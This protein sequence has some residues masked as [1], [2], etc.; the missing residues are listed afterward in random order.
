VDKP[1][2]IYSV[3]GLRVNGS[4][5][6]ALYRRWTDRGQKR[7]SSRN[8]AFCTLD[9]VDMQA[10]FHNG[11]RFRAV[12]LSRL[13]CFAGKV[14]GLCLAV[15]IYR[16]PGSLRTSLHQVLSCRPMRSLQSCCFACGRFRFVHA[17]YAFLF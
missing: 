6:K 12:L 15:S 8:A 11:C 9:P 10:F 13:A 2:F 17:A 7:S 3:N 1:G 16:W 14:A 5:G 4:A